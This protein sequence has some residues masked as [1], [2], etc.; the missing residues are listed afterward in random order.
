MAAGN[1]ENNT[2]VKLHEIS[3]VLEK[4]KGFED[5]GEGESLWDLFKENNA[6]LIDFI[7]SKITSMN[8][9]NHLLYASVCL[10]SPENKKSTDEFE[11][12]KQIVDSGWGILVFNGEANGWKIIHDNEKEMEAHFKTRASLYKI[13]KEYRGNQCGDDNT[14][15]ACHK[16]EDFKSSDCKHYKDCREYFEFI[17]IKINS[18]TNAA[19]DG[20][21]NVKYDDLNKFI[22]DKF[23]NEFVNYLKWM[24]ETTG[25]CYYFR[26]PLVKGVKDFDAGEIYLA[27]DLTALSEEKAEQTA[28]ETIRVI[29]DYI[30]VPLLVRQMDLEHK[31]TKQ[32]KEKSE[33]S[34]K[35]LNHLTKPLESLTGALV[36]VQKNSQDLRAILYDPHRSIFA[37]ASGVQ[38]FFIHKKVVSIGNVRWEIEHDADKYKTINDL[39]STLSGIV[40]EI[41]GSDYR[42]EN[43]SDLFNH[44]MG[45]VFM[46]TKPDPYQRLRKT[47]KDILGFKLEDMAGISNSLCKQ[48]YSSVDKT[49][50]AHAKIIDA[51]TA[52]K[53]I[54]HYPFKPSE[55]ARKNYLPLMVILDDIGYPG[56]IEFENNE[57]S[58]KLNGGNA[59]RSFL[60]NREW[61]KHCFN[62][63]SLSLP[64]YSMFIDFVSS[65]IADINTKDRRIKKIIITKN[66]LEVQLAA[67][68]ASIFNSVAGSLLTVV[69]T[70]KISEP[71]VH[72][73]DS[74]KPFLDLIYNAKSMYKDNTKAVQNIECELSEDKT[75][76]ISLGE[77]SKVQYSM[78][79]LTF[80]L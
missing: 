29:R 79:G 37:A 68:N 9:S 74:Q 15:R 45:L 71:R 42:P 18:N 59:V 20:E 12:Y 28:K 78:S 6:A 23:S 34:E 69:N 11:Q 55:T 1:G 77:K 14:D 25:E 26:K 22:K 54:L 36:K 51:V 50:P 33:K 38:E 39:I 41:F 62:Q 5:G 27:M 47:C 31:A 52:F 24:N 53:Y 66:S 46:E 2:T 64:C 57:N 4:W 10:L 61:N 72:G 58:F 35:M 7:K 32:E 19:V 80:S 16:M 63:N 3:D 8:V 43:P 67:I 13:C 73:G 56:E 30:G 48:E 65:F 17:K 76:N 40:M 44:A 60:E 21:K 75:L 49:N 70:A